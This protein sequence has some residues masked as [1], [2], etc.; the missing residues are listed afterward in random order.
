[1]G[2]TAIWGV[3]FFFALALPAAAATPAPPPGPS[4]ALHEKLRSGDEAQVREALDE[5]RT[6]GKAALSA[7][8]WVGE[9]LM[10]GVTAPVA[11]AALDTLGDMETDSQVPIVAWYA[12]H[13]VLAVR[14]AAIRSLVKGKGTLAVRALR[15]ALADEDPAVRGLSA[16]GLGA[17]KAQ[18]ATMDL[19]AALEHGV[20]E[21]AS[22]I[23]M[24]CDTKE[25]EL[26]IAK[27]GRVPFDVVTSGIEQLLF[28][29]ATDVPDDVK[30]KVV[31]KL[32]ELGT[33]ESNKFLRDV[34]QRW[35]KGASARVRQALEQGVMATSGSPQ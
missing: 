1:M 14:R 24:I 7:A 3:G 11:E 22:S 6:E 9:V 19:L 31:G 17:L 21:A 10:R 15:R 23:G 18:E 8:P 13:R 4:A 33:A 30:I 16:T 12:R 5:L 34:Q 29:P 32:R 25:C 28:R 26:L 2:R 35:P 27:L 20:P